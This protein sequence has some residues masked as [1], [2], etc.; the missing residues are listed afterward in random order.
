MQELMLICSLKCKNLGKF[1]FLSEEFFWLKT[2]TNDLEK[3]VLKSKIALCCS[4]HKTER[5]GEKTPKLLMVHRG[6]GILS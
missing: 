3:E 1:G 6:S 2:T 4:S 5:G